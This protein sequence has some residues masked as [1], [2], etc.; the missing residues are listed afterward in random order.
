[1]TQTMQG[2]WSGHTDTLLSSTQDIRL[3]GVGVEV[4]MTGEFIPYGSQDFRHGCQQKNF[5]F[6]FKFDLTTV[7]YALTTCVEFN[8][9]M[10]KTAKLKNPSRPHRPPELN[11]RHFTEQTVR[12]SSWHFTCMNPFNSHNPTTYDLIF[13]LFYS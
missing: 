8:C 7:Y 5:D 13:S 4:V 3:Y 6:S 1:M 12:H 9:Q 2:P 10:L 11:Y